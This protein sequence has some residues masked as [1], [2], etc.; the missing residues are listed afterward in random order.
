M[1]S[2]FADDHDVV[3]V[4]Y[5]GVD[6]STRL[7]CPE[8]DVG[9]QP[10]PRPAQRARAAR[11]RHRAARLRRPPDSPRA[12]PRRLHGP[13]ARRRPRGRAPALNYGKVD[14]VSESAGTRTAQIYAW[15]YPASIHRSVLVAVNPPG[16]FLFSPKQT[17]AQ[18][19]A[20][21]RG[22]ERLPDPSARRCPTAG[23]R[24]RSS[25]GNVR[26]GSFFGLMESSSKAAPADGADD[27]RRPGARRPTA[28]RA[29]SGSSRS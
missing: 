1:A 9:A 28:T 19:D 25:R 14:L 4:G 8:V 21:V 23:V 7:D 2:R 27:A 3:L 15:R 26:V 5:R 18:L 22:P 20:A 10:P 13:A 24:S 6:S 16:R 11:V 12:R 17:D 29:G